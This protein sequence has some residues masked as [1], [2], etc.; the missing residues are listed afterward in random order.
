VRALAAV[1]AYASRVGPSKCCKIE[2]V[3]EEELT[4]DLVKEM[5]RL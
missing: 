2:L 1:A 5:Y 4:L 3:Q